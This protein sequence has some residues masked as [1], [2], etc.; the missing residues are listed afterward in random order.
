MN[1]KDKYMAQTTPQLKT[2]L[3]KLFISQEETR[4]TAC[5]Y[6]P[7]ITPL[8]LGNFGQLFVII[9]IDSTKEENKKIITLL[10]DEIKSAYYGSS[11]FTIEAALENALGRGNEK[12]KELITSGLKSWVEKFNAIV[13]VIK[14][15]ELHFTQVGHTNAFLIHQQKIIN[16]LENSAG[17]SAN[18]NPLKV[19]SNVISGVLS[20]DDSVLFCTSSLLDYLSQEKL[21]RIISTSSPDRAVRELYTLLEEGAH[22]IPF[23]A[24]ILKQVLS[25][26]EAKMP[27]STVIQ[28][29]SSSDQPDQSMSELI[30]KEESTAEYLTPSVWPKVTKNLKF[31][32][33]SAQSFLQNKILRTQTSRIKPVKKEAKAEPMETV[34]NYAQTKRFIPQKPQTLGTRVMQG[35]KSGAAKFFQLV[36]LAIKK[37]FSLFRSQRRTHGHIR[38]LPHKT[39]QGMASWL[40][41]L[42]D[43]PLK[44]K[45]ILGCAIL[46][47][48]VFA[49]NIVNLGESK[50]EKAQ[51]E[52]YVQDLARARELASKAE[53]ALIYENEEEARRLLTEA[54]TL[55]NAI[56]TEEENLQVDKN[57][58]LS[59]IQNSLDTVNHLEKIADPNLIADL[60]QSN[61]QIDVKNIFLAAGSIYAL[62]SNGIVAQTNLADQETKIVEL[63]GTFDQKIITATQRDEKNFIVIDANNTFYK[64]NLENKAIDK[65]SVQSENTDQKIVA[66][67]TY[68][69]RLYVL[70]VK[71]N[72]IFRHEQAGQGFAKGTP[73]LGE[74]IDVKEVN[75]LAIDGSLWLAKNNGEITK[76][77]AG[78]KADDFTLSA[79]DPAFSAAPVIK[80][81]I[82][83]SNL[84]LLDPN[85]KR[86]V[87]L[88]KDGS[89]VKQIY[90]EKFDYL[91]DLALDENSSKIYLL[92]GN[93]L[94]S[95]DI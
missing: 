27:T 89:L 78:S 79:L 60:T 76:L 15:H 72:Q 38:T 12:L 45:I 87:I 9:E 55:L 37:I 95:A 40:I 86:V 85:N 44:Q 4:S 24:I 70:D 47:I 83:T 31:Y 22:E 1:L 94:Y 71:N 33:I 69:S 46:L 25:Q 29:I 20:A 17:P 28:A 75:S 48:V 5:I 67:G 66:L 82:T 59:L 11:D 36:L 92:N 63:S 80:A 39:S 84:Y 18:I 13:G 19:F 90:S 21:R 62:D 7:K 81:S 58:S 88:K 65:I 16:I 35:V 50:E 2:K 68:L 43:A 23:A 6:L 14:N 3:A 77:H 30:A 52:Q 57:N 93:A 49:Y 61:P 8:E 51:K 41:R 64:L 32:L 74:G 34:K 54:K 56:P 42:K 53:S 26:E 73:W 91:K 10:S